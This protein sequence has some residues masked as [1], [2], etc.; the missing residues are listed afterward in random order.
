MNLIEYGLD[1]TM[2]S[3]QTSRIIPARVLEANREIFTLICEHGE[4]SARLKGTFYKQLSE[5]QSMPVVGDFVKIQYNPAGHSLISEVMPRKSIFFRTDL[6]GHA[7]GYVKTVKAQVVAV[8]FDYVFIMV[9]LNHDFNMNRIQ[10][11]FS[12]AL[13]SGALPVIVLTK[14]DINERYESI[15]DEVSSFTGCKQVY[16]ISALTGLGLSALEKYFTLGKTIA[17]IGSSGVG[18]STLVNAIAGEEVMKVGEVRE[19]DSKG[20]HTTTTRELI[21]LKNGALIIDTPGMRELGIFEAEEGLTMAFEDVE[22]IIENCKYRDCRHDREPG[23]AVREALENRTL[24]RERWK[25]YNQ[26]GSE[27]RWGTAKV[28]RT[29][30]EKLREKIRR[31]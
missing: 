24:T 23:C 1:A 3:G 26:L 18:K 12:I 9:A 5:D 6:S 15:V 25:L 16:A 10:R 29:K 8:N 7:P 21:K 13:Q 22:A 19:S 2:V 30:K 11:Y 27:N 17:I 31:H 14:A 28:A 4:I 20:R